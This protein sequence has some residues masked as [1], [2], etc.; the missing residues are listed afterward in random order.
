MRGHARNPRAARTDFA[1]E[2]AQSG[3]RAMARGAMLL[4]VMRALAVFVT[5]GMAIIGLVRQAAGELEHVRRVERA[6][7]L[8]R[9]T[10]ARIEAG[11]T[12][13]QAAGGPVRAWADDP[14]AMEGDPE[15]G[16]GGG[17]FADAP[18]A[19]SGW[20]V[21]VEVEPSEFTGLT[22]VSVTATERGERDAVRA[23]Y[24]LR[25][26]VRLSAAEE[27]KAGDE[28]R[29]AEEARKGL[30]AREERSK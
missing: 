21:A 13:P 9:S 15:A 16:E 10:M 24:T 3:A 11:I 28:D 17:G 23:A 2:P 30:R 5:A 26:L 8:A 6:A 7:D 29:L 25:Q 19:K 22:L 1:S 4:E 12:S 18:P 20:E 14:E 27:D